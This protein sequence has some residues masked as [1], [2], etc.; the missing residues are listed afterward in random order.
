MLLSF[1]RRATCALLLLLSSHLSAEELRSEGSS[2]LGNLMK[3][4][5]AAFSAQLPSVSFN[6]NNNGSGAAPQALL[7]GRVNFAAMSRA[8]SYDELRSFVQAGKNKPLRIRVA[9]DT[10]SIIVH[11]DNPISGLNLQQIDAIFSA[12][13]LCGAANSI[14]NWSQL[15]GANAPISVMG[16]DTHSGTYGFFK[17]RILCK[18]EHSQ[19]V[20]VFAST[21]L[22][23]HAVQNN[24]NSIGY[25]GSGAV[26]EGKRVLPIS[27]RINNDYV[28][29][30][31][32]NALEGRYPLRRFLYIY[33]NSDEQ[34]KIAP[35]EK[36]FLE[37]ILSSKG[38]AIVSENGFT[39]LS[40]YITDKERSRF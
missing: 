32:T 13:R 24:V 40:E 19:H 38:Q 8:M 33:V 18:G 28:Q 25:L 4:W 37:F 26:S 27:K 2:T 16:H 35:L 9:L 5:S 22:L 15:G 14:D 12:N 34:G 23:T 29:P 6:L 3:S 36:T 21:P 20:Q 11:E 7:E 1:S 39:A 31:D 30:T 17:E 10:L